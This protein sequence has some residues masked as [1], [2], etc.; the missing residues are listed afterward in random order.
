MTSSIWTLKF[1]LVEW[2]NTTTLTSQV[3]SYDIR[4]VSVAAGLCHPHDAGLGLV[5]GSEVSDQEG[6]RLAPLP[7]GE[8]W[9]VSWFVSGAGGDGTA[10]FSSSTSITSWR[11]GRWAL[12]PPA[13][14]FSTI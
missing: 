5:L 3:D 9:L 8:G 10:L 4:I 14:F 12:L 6:S 13:T 1:A 11:V 7:S 2:A